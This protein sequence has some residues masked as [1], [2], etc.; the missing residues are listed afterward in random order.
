VISEDE[1]A[2]VAAALQTLRAAPEPSPGEAPPSRWKRA[3]RYP[4][5]E[6]E[7]IRVR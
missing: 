1:L 6:I 3:D 5:L 2:A 4:E 7:D